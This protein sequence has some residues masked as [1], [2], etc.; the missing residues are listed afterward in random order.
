M[1][2]RRLWLDNFH[3]LKDVEIIFDDSPSMYGS[4][5]IR[6]FVGLNGS[7]KSNA[8]EAIGLIFSHLAADTN[9]ASNSTS[10]TN[11]VDGLSESQPGPMHLLTQ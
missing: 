8:L 1:R 10:S 9:P 4:T 7:G 11:C 6:F 2:L 3:N 5:S